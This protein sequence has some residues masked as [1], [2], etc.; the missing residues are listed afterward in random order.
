L[1]TEHQA[2]R[3]ELAAKTFLKVADAIH[4]LWKQKGSSDTRLLDRPWIPND[5]V[6]VGESHAGKDRREH[7]IPR[8]MICMRAREMFADGRSPDDVAAFL[9]AHVKIVLIS[10]AEQERLDNKEHLNLR[11]GMPDGWSFES[12]DVY[13]RLTAAE[14]SFRLYDPA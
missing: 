8:M 9:R 1:T 2:A 14:I 13:A 3:E 4:E 11:Q 10:K 7:L 6:T 5:M 12:G